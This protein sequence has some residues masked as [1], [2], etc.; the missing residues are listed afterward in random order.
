MGNRWWSPVRIWQREARG[1]EGET[2]YTGQG[3]GET[4]VTSTEIGL[5]KTAKLVE[6]EILVSH[7]AI[8]VFLGTKT[9]LVE[10]AYL[11]WLEIAEVS[12]C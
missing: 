4:R 6:L 7:S 9:R 1:G 10:M 3:T 8:S 12:H 11:V 5:L 2:D